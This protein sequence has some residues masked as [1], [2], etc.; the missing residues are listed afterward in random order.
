MPTPKARSSAPKR[1]PFPETREY[2]RRVLAA[3]REYRATYAR[4]LGL[5]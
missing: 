3:Q 4:A 5:E 1:F 2:V